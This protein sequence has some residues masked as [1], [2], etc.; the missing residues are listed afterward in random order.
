ML[1]YDTSDIGGVSIAT[2]V[3]NTAGAHLLN[4]NAVQKR[5]DF[6]DDAPTI[7]FADSTYQFMV[8]HIMKS[9]QHGDAK[10]TV[11]MDFDNDKE[12]DAPNERVY[13]GYTSVGNFTLTNNITIPHNV[14]TDVPTG[15]R[16]ILNNDI[17]PNTP[18]DLA[19]G[20][21][22]SG[23]TTDLI[24]QFER[25][26]PAGIGAMNSVTDFGIFPNP[27]NGKFSLQFTTKDAKDV[28]VTITNVTG[29][30]I[31]QFAFRHNGGLFNKE[32]DM[33]GHASGV[34]FVEI[35]AGEE[36]AKKKLVIK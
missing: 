24:V 30:Q 12:Y 21:Y 36:I 25:N 3:K 2:F 15:M 33:T 26:F 18:S 29:Q 34:Y 16:V 31:E 8:Y 4:A 10:I 35:K 23:E 17:A 14:I 6:T 9:A 13:T 19:C 5:E 27:N 20:P 7:L 28:V 1:F 22:Q 32:M 11:F